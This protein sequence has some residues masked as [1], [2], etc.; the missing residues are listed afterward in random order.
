LQF[1]TQVE[2]VTTFLSAL[3]TVHVRAKIDMDGEEEIMEQDIAKCTVGQHGCVCVGVC[4]KR[5]KWSV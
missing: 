2:E 1:I 5:V 4:V 3:P